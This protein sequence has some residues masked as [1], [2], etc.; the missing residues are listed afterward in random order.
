MTIKSRTVAIIG[1]GTIGLTLAWHLHNLGYRVKLIDPQL[2]NLIQAK[3][4]SF[5]AT[6]ILMGCTYK[7]KKGRSWQLRKRSISLWPQWCASLQRYS[8]NLTYRAG[9][10][11]LASNKF[12]ENWQRQMLCE[13]TGIHMRQWDRQKLDSLTPEIPKSISSALFSP[14]DGQIDPKGMLAS[15]YLQI[16]D[17]KIEIIPKRVKKITRLKD[18]W[19]LQFECGQSLTSHWSILC[20]GSDFSV[21]SSENSNSFETQRIRGQ[22]LHLQLANTI[23]NRWEY[24]PG[25]VI[26]RGNSLVPISNNEYWIGSTIEIDNRTKGSTLNSLLN[27]HHIV[28]EWLKRSN[29]IKHWQGIRSRPMYRL[30]PILQLVAPRLILATA[31]YR[32]GILLAPSTVEW[33]LKCVRIVDRR[34]SYEAG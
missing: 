14:E 10:L 31:F 32:N 19:Y 11:F 26:W 25:S 30:S 13:R 18:L 33:V 23:S 5:A 15:I 12:E 8:E 28:P 20:A 9:I 24:W 27:R 17:K 7:K 34:C 16:I 22:S 29:I 2:A 4:S 21:P 1:A 6:G 3:S